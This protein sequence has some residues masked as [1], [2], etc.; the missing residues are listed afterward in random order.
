[1]ILKGPVRLRG[2]RR[3]GKTERQACKEG[4]RRHESKE[5]PGF[6]VRPGW[7]D[8]GTGSS[9]G[10]W[11]LLWSLPHRKTGGP[12]AALRQEPGAATMENSIE[13]PQKTRNKRQREASDT[14]SVFG[15]HYLLR[16]TCISVLGLFE[17]P[18]YPYT[19]N[20]PFLFKMAQATF[21]YLQPKGF[22]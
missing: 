13:V 18:L 14:F 5:S 20:F 4:A 16:S 19:V 21:C 12:G 8:G 6:G 3:D 22:D 9:S 10:L 7:V 11:Q 17:S 2:E 15:S 1:M